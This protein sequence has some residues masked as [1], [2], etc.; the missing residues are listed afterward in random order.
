MC[1]P[2]NLGAP[3]AQ[4]VPN[5]MSAKRGR[6]ARPDHAWTPHAPP[7]LELNS[8]TEDV[9]EALSVA[10]LVDTDN[11]LLARTI[12]RV[13]ETKGDRSHHGDYL[14]EIADGVW[15]GDGIAV[16]RLIWFSDFR[17]RVLPL[18]LPCRML[19]VCSPKCSRAT[20]LPRWLTSSQWEVVTRN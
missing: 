12:L 8:I 13:A 5:L 20:A 15:N 17:N 19:S 7:G 11:K 14:N 6:H 9:P 3:S 16:Q 1:Q 2:Q 4:L 10:D 18:R